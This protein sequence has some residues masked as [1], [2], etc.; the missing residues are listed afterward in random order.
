MKKILVLL[1]VLFL[2]ISSAWGEELPD[3]AKLSADRMRFDSQTGDFLATGNV[4]IQAD[5]LTLLAPRGT[6]NVK[7]KEVVFSEGVLISGDWQGDWVDL[8]AGSV[9]LTF[10]E[11]AVYL[12]EN[13]VKGD[14]GKITIDSDKLSL[15]GSEWVAVNVRL[16]EDRE[17]DLSFG[18]KNVQGTLADGILIHLT[19]ENDVWLKGRPN[20]TGEVVDIRGNKAVYSVERGSVV[21]SGNVKAVQKGRTLTS[22]SIVYFPSLNRIEAIGGT[23]NKAPSKQRATI[24]IDLKQEKQRDKK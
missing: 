8:K 5:G 17:A 18:A 1:L 10:G 12:I 23:D 21:L 9:S 14:L 20:N 11:R 4:V 19:A 3:E 22:Q 6:G 16:L 7:R 13:G 15:E 2:S 24:T